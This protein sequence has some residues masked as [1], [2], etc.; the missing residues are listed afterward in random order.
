MTP[1]RLLL[2]WQCDLGR[3]RSVPAPEPVALY[4]FVIMPT[5]P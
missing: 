1:R 4:F 3:D 5:H 2:K